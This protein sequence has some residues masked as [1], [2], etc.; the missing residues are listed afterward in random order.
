[1][2]CDARGVAGVRGVPVRLAGGRPPR[3]PAPAAPL[4]KARPRQALRLRRSAHFC[5]VQGGLRSAA[6]TRLC[7]AELR[8]SP[9]GRTDDLS[10][11]AERF[12]EEV[13][14]EA[15]G[16]EPEVGS[17]VA[18]L[19]AAEARLAALQARL[20]ALYCDTFANIEVPAA[21]EP[22]GKEEAAPPASEAAFSALG[23]DAPAAFARLMA[24]A[25]RDRVRF[26]KF[27]AE[28]QQLALRRDA[29]R[30]EVSASS[31]AL[32]AA[33]R[34]LCKDDEESST[35]PVSAGTKTVVLIS[36]FESFNVSLYKGVARRLAAAA[37]NVRL[38]VFSD[39]DIESR[40]ADVEAA[41][42]SA[43]AFVGSLL[44][45]FDQ[46]E[47]LRE[48]LGRVPL[49][50]A[51][52]CSLELMSMTQCGSFNMSGQSRG[53]P[54]AVKALLA[55]L[56]SGREEDKMLGY[57]SMLK[58][59]PS[60]LRFVPGTG[61]RHLRNWVTVYSA[62]NAGGAD[63][64]LRAFTHL[65]TE[66]LGA[67]A[68]TPAG[69]APAA[70]DVP[71]TGC[72]HPELAASGR[73]IASPR[74]YLAWYARTHSPPAD[75]PVVAVLLYRKHVVS[76]LP[77]LTQL[78]TRLEQDG[79]IPL[80]IFI[81]GVEAHAIV[82]DSLTTRHEAAQ[83][84]AG[85]V[86][87]G[88]LRSD[89]AIVDAIVST[90]GFPLVG[91]PAGS[92]EGGRQADVAQAILNAKNVPYFVA[93]PLL[94]QDLASWSADGVAALQ[95]VVLYALPELDAA[96]DVL[97]LGGLVGDDVYL[98]P[99]RVGVL[100]TR[101]RAWVELRRR[102]N[103]DKRVAIILYGFPPGA[104]AVG[105][106]ALLNVPASLEATLARLA[107]EGYDLGATQLSGETI[108]AALTALEGAPVAARGLA[109]A[110]DAL[111]AT[112][113]ER[114]VDAAAA[115][116][117]GQDVSAATLRS[118]LT[119]PDTW[120]PDEWG[121]VPTLPPPDLL[122]AR[123]ERAWGSL[124]TYTG[125]RAAVSSPGGGPGVFS[126]AGIQLGNVFI[127]V[128][129][130]LGIEGDPMRLLF[131]R[132]LTPHPQ[133]ASFYKWLGKEGFDAHAL[134]HFG[135][136]GTAEWLPGSPLG[137]TALSWPEVLLGALPNLYIYAANN[138]SE[139][140]VAKRRGFGTIV[141]HGVPPYGRAGL[142]RRLAEVQTLLAEWREAPRGADAL[143]APIVD[144]IAAAGLAAD[145]PFGAEGKPLDAESAATL[146]SAEFEE[147]A[148]RVGAYLRLLE[149]R[150]FSEGLHTLGA[151]PTAAAM[152][153]YL[154]AYFQERLP[155]AAVEVIA[156]GA[157]LEAARASLE[158]AYAGGAAAPNEEAVAE[159]VQIRDLL[160]RAPEELD[161]LIAGLNGEY[162]RPA[163][164][165]DLLRD[166]AGALPTG[167]NIHALDPYR[168]PTPGALA[169]GAAAARAILETH[170]KSAAGG[171]PYPETVSVNL[172]GLDAI[173]TKGESV[174]CLLE[175]VGA[176]PLREGT[177]R[178]VRFELRPLSELGR[179]R[180]DVLVNMSGIFRDSF[181][182]VATLLDDMFQRAAAADEPPEK[183]F[184]RKHALAATAAGIGAPA[185]RLFSNP[186]GDYGS[187][188]NERVG[189]SDWENG[190]E[191]GD[192]WVAR[193]AFSYGRGSERG[194]P[195]PE[196][197]QSLLAT[198]ER[199]IQVRAPI[200][201]IQPDRALTQAL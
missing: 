76:Q 70:V 18:E 189:A 47:W 67:A 141:S 81:S 188:V 20:D 85:N 147:Y 161:A 23:R 78:V 22:E 56:G 131:E 154:S 184:I 143:R 21:D 2:L 164:G 72:F 15:A 44:F 13:A 111:K 10:S 88:S 94:I 165:G 187:M 25:A 71:L 114:G 51:F 199:V 95:S 29:A 1:M 196:L 104:G 4:A 84:A 168:M 6:F 125:M 160:A 149:N 121:P 110:A 14:R 12:A 83:R 190:D 144:A 27:Q 123:M 130:A 186:P 82:R 68:S 93:A 97:P 90:I 201:D 77:Y 19:T 191:L 33:Q 5:A 180:V 192:T 89:A 140:I 24:A 128:Q 9:G 138:P 127:G 157:S 176:T 129:P 75:A 39:R 124:E 52:E 64:V 166:G 169:R 96:I 103:A 53:P 163:P 106:A 66:Y 30:R 63:N 133:Y 113:A 193:N 126:V 8:R 122:V 100:A 17:R 28:A 182:N 11:A 183:N 112:L 45:D 43:D 117:A 194:T 38:L 171:S 150:L 135:M 58:T 55:K 107:S 115:Q 105:T 174:G 73:Y 175:L 79:V 69:A 60:L 35:A 7:F 92:M 153:Q 185:A 80:P 142:Y 148:S 65:S 31:A 26:N 116:V 87:V 156:G 118:W 136:H 91:G 181:G 152:S 102:A 108:V 139:T 42:A 61:A 86:S 158:A 132:D 134:L 3:P 59:L 146:T 41:L 16:A 159:A 137:S 178:V 151:P 119:L 74:E 109:G 198:T 46:I 177:G 173:K 32:V 48:R 98:C 172:W 99:E 40:R 62:W 36:G 179:P 120:G 170:A 167:R 57:L 197:L 49:R 162:I 34:A 37:P 101:I 145:C 54:P 155:P 195:R 50:L 200:M